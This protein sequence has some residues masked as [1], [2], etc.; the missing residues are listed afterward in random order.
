MEII[1]NRPH[2]A[3]WETWLEFT[4]T[5]NKGSVWHDRHEQVWCRSQT[6]IGDNLEHG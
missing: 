5:L 3:Q 1:S 4:N 2:K 6:R